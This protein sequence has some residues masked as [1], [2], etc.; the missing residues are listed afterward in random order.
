MY[1]N[2]ESFNYICF[3]C[4]VKGKNIVQF[5]YNLIQDGTISEYDV[6]DE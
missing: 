3:K 1:V 6:K 5:V 2:K 4:G